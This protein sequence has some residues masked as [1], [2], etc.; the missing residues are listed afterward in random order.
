MAFGLCYSPATYVRVIIPV[1][2]RLTWWVVLAYL[3]DI[4]VLGKTNGDHLENLEVVLGGSGNMV[5]S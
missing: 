2:R 1:L 5:S 3:D 4:L